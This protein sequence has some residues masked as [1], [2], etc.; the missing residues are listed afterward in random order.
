MSA[1]SADADESHARGTESDSEFELVAC[2]EG[3]WGDGSSECEYDSDEPIPLVPKLEAPRARPEA[4]VADK[5][6]LWVEDVAFQVG[7]AAHEIRNA[8]RFWAS[9]VTDSKGQASL[10]LYKKA[11]STA[12]KLEATMRAL[13]GRVRNNP[14]LWRQVSRFLP[15]AQGLLTSVQ[16]DLAPLSH[17]GGVSEEQRKAAQQL[18]SRQVAYLAALAEALAVRHVPESAPDLPPPGKRIDFDVWRDQENRFVA[19]VGQAVAAKQVVPLEQLIGLA[20]LACN[21][22]HQLQNLASAPR[23]GFGSQAHKIL[24]L[25]DNRGGK[26]ENASRASMVFAHRAHQL[27]NAK[28]TAKISE[29]AL[30]LQEAAE[31]C[32]KLAEKA[33]SVEGGDTVPAE[34]YKVVLERLAQLAALLHGSVPAEHRQ[35]IREK[36]AKGAG[37]AKGK[38]AA[39]IGS[40]CA[41]CNFA[42]TGVTLAHCCKRC[43][44]TNGKQ[45]G[46]ACKQQTVA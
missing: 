34:A 4:P 1:N 14:K 13:V 24:K 10:Q 3:G 19:E 37:K 7:N 29:R 28:P 22:S 16:A 32:A 8:L 11:D 42:V 33:I 31:S 2:E 21:S 35:S 44:K 15:K 12:G 46:P 41:G 9:L 40:K 17:A 45:H 27:Q 38:A 6:S 20:R 23:G 18:V 26:C 30:F 5:D 36:K 25:I 43:E 39:A